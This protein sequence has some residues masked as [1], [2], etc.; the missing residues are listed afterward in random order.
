MAAVI[1][2]C[3]F[4]AARAEFSFYL[5]D[6]FESGQADK[7]YHFGNVAAELARN[8]SLEAGVQDTIADSCGDYSLKMKGKTAAWYIGGIGAELLADASPFSRFQMD[9]NGNSGGGKI[10]IE[11]FCYDNSTSTE[12]K[13]TNHKWIAEVPVLG[14]GFSRISIP[15]SAFKPDGSASAEGGWQPN[16]GGPN[17]L[18]SIQFILLAAQA[19]GEAEADIDNILLTY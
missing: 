12:A 14:Q 10:K 16:K 9:V 6:N 4:Q 17:I 5:I 2:L 13:K 3:L 19:T 8:P 1:G 7:W 18:Q 15:F 11:L